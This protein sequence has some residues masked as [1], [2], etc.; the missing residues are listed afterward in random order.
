MPQHVHVLMAQSVQRSY[1]KCRQQQ[2]EHDLM[3]I[4]MTI[5]NDMEPSWNALYER[6]AFCNAFDIANYVADY[7]TQRAGLETCS[8]SHRIY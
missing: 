5:V 7:L 6:D 4:M 2:Q 8:C 1:L 3:A